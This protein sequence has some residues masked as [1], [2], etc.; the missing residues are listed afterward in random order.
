VYPYLPSGSILVS[1]IQGGLYVV[2]DE[3]DADDK[4]NISFEAASYQVLEGESVELTVTKSGLQAASIDYEIILGSTQN[5][6]AQVE[7]R[8]TLEWS[9]DDDTN[10]TITIEALEDGTSENSETLFVRLI[11]PSA[12]AEIKG[13]YITAVEIESLEAPS[14]VFAF[15]IDELEVK[16]IDGQISVDVNRSGTSNAALTLN[17]SLQDISSSSSDYELLTDTLS[18]EENDISTKTVMVNIIN[19]EQTES[20]ESFT[21]VLSSSQENVEFSSSSVT[22]NILDDESNAAPTVTL[23]SETVNV[24]TRQTVTITAV[25]NDPEGAEIDYQWE[26]TAGDSVSLTGRNDASISFAAPETA[27]TISFTVSVTD[28]FEKVSTASVDVVVAEPPAPPPATTPAP[29][30][31]PEPPSNS[32]GGSLFWLIGL[33][34]ISLQMRFTFRLKPRNY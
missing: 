2:K 8:G 31:T 14:S 23:E 9:I 29:A 25:G 4:A 3:T 24:N 16:E 10:K 11:N 1:D 12:D 22:V 27:Q 34:L 30:P 15:D 26:Q 20:E 5:E 17:V 32:S 33:L 19:D 28:D 7:T 6:D 21:I 13:R 18:W